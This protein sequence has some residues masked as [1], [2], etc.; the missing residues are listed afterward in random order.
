[1]SNCNTKSQSNQIQQE[2][3]DTTIKNCEADYATIDSNLISQYKIRLTKGDNHE[4]LFIENMLNLIHDFNNKKL[5][6]T[7]LT[8]G[9]ISND[10][11]IDTIQTRIFYKNNVI[12]VTYN[13]IKNHDTLW[14][15]QIKDP[16]LFVS[17]DDLF[18]DKRSV[19]VTF[20]VGVYLVVPK[21]LKFNDYKYLLE[22]SFDRK[23]YF[24]KEGIDLNE[25]RQYINNFKGN[26]LQW[27]DNWHI[28]GVY[29]WY[30]PLKRLILYYHP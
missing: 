21:I 11:L 7:V 6:T 9:Y 13:W 23:K 30:E 29:I 19:W 1:L 16:Y 28:E 8:I 4:K 5:D 15:F 20:T 24:K 27:G 26:L 3:K 2:I 17:N 25:Y 12:M 10:S 14:N 18:I 22:M